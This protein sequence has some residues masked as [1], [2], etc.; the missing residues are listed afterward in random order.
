MEILKNR[1]IYLTTVY[2]DS[3]LNNDKRIQLRKDIN[4]AWKEVYKE[5]GRN[6]LNPLNDD[7]YLKAHWTMF[8]T[9]SRN[10]GDDYIHDLLGK[11]F[12]QKSFYL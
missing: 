9:Y 3:Q 8:F 11:R 12:N 6:S 1:L 7:E 10:M 2:T 4:D 5:L